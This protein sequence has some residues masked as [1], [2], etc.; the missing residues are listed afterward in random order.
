MERQ[1]QHFN[2]R[3]KAVIKACNE[4]ADIAVKQGTAKATQIF[5]NDYLK[6]RWN[7][8]EHIVIMRLVQQYIYCKMGQITRE[9]CMSEQKKSL[10]MLAPAGRTVRKETE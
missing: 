7:V 3:K 6:G 8:M 5:F 1:K 9:A 10:E 2:Q 4:Y